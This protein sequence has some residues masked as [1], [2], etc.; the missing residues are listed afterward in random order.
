LRGGPG[1]SRDD[2]GTSII[3]IRSSGV[4]ISRPFGRRFW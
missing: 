4:I 1:Q 2:F 3:E